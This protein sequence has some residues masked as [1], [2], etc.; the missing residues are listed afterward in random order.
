MS[1]FAGLDISTAFTAICIV[2]ADGVVISETT[3]DST[4]EGVMGFL[5]GAGVAIERIGLEACPL[6][7]WLFESLAEGGYPVLCLETRHLQGLLKS[8]INKTGRNDARGIAQAVRVKLFRP[9]HVKT[10]TARECRALLSAR[11]LVVGEIR[12]VENHLRGTLKAFG[13]KT[14]KTS[15]RRFEARIRELVAGSPALTE[16]ADGLLVAV[17]MRIAAH[18]PRRSGR[19]LSTIRLLPRVIDGKPLVRPW[20]T[21]GGARPQDFGHALQSLPAE[22]GSLGPPAQC[23]HP[24]AL[25]PAAERTDEPARPWDG[26]VVEPALVDRTRRPG[27]VPVQPGAARLRVARPPVG[28]ESVDRAGSHRGE[29]PAHRHCSFRRDGPYASPPSRP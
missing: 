19:G 10:R 7:E 20:V 14:G 16:I 23:A 26:K 12:K 4:P 17:G 3:V 2:D 6:S 13:L 28:R 25:Q 8:G 9:V 24:Q 1:C 22:A 29:D 5:D 18:P 15:R 27:R 11:R 21:D